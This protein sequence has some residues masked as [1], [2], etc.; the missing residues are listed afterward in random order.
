MALFLYRFLEFIGQV[1]T[2]LV[3]QAQK[4]PQHV[5]HFLAKCLASIVSASRVTGFP[6]LLTIPTANDSRQFAHFLRQNR[7]IGEF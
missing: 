5:C 1:D 4:D 6:R 2:G 3:S 7:H